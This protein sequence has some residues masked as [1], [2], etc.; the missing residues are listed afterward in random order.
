MAVIALDY[1]KLPSDQRIAVWGGLSGS[2][3]GIQE[4]SEPTEAELNNTGGASGMIQL[5][6]ALSW[7]DT[8]LPGLRASEE[9]NEPSLADPANYVE[10]GPSNY[11]ATLSMFRPL[12]YDDASNPLSI[13]YDLMDATDWRILDFA[14]RIDGDK[15]ALAPAEDGDYVT[16]T[17]QRLLTEDNPFNFDESA[18]RTVGFSGTG[19]FAHYT[20][21][22]EHELNVIT[23]EPT[24]TGT[25]GRFVVEVQGRDYTNALQF[26]SRNPDVI[27]VSPGGFYSVVGTGAYEVVVSDS[28]AGTSTVISGQIA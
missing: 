20:I 1:T 3:S 16:V 17:R 28:G 19:G 18:R 12:E 26:F 6:E 5:S 10:F 22:G 15:D 14:V 23:P 24:A 27:R 11:D 25:K 2:T 21:V 13:A 8:E 4:V 9:S 7:S